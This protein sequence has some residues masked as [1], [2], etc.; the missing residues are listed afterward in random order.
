MNKLWLCGLFFLVTTIEANSQRSD[1]RWEGGIDRGGSV[2]CEI[3]KTGGKCMS[4]ANCIGNLTAAQDRF[5]MHEELELVFLGEHI[6]QYAKGV[7]TCACCN[8]TLFHSRDKFDS[9]RGHISFTKPAKHAIVGYKHHEGSW[10]HHPRDTG[11]HCEKC[12][13]HIG[14]FLLPAVL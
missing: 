3:G 9:N 1:S 2:N 13:A 5:C 6:Y 8:T 12:G 7:Y 10:S 4:P 11:I 14:E